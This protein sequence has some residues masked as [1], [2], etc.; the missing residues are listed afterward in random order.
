M[1]YILGSVIGI[2]ALI[3]IW[4]AWHRVVVWRK[5]LRKEVR[6]AQDTL[7]TTFDALHEDISEQL[8][9]VQDEKTLDHA[10]DSLDIAEKFVR[11]E[12]EDIEKEVE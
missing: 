12:I 7:H 8:E 2:M 3:V 11:K 1:I 10:E 9:N 5:R 6:E 4:Y